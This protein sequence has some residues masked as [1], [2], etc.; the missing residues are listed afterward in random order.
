MDKISVIVPV[1]KVE[2]YLDKCVESIVNQTYQ[3]L[4]I[5]LVDDGSPDRCP[6]MCD[7][8]AKKDPRI[9]VIHKKNGGLSS[10]RNAG[11]DQACGDYLM[12]VDSDDYISHCMC[13]KL[14]QSIVRENAD[15][16]ICGVEKK[17]PNGR[18]SEFSNI[19]DGVL[20]QKAFFDKMEGVC[21]WCWV[22]AWNKLY[23]KSIFDDLRYP[24]GKL[25]EDD[26][27]IHKIISKTQSISCVG[28]PLYFYVQRENSI[29]SSKYTVKNLDSVEAMLQRC[30]FFIDHDF[31]SRRIDF[32]LKNAL[33]FLYNN[34]TNQKH[35]S[36]F[37]ARY[38]QL[39]SY[40]KTIWE[41]A[42]NFDLPLSRKLYYSAN[43]L[44]PKIGYILKKIFR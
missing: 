22:V 23:K 24:E 25:Y 37:N 42:K 6:Q 20:T 13:E 41:K 21:G 19:S 39:I 31:E 7:E 15:M 12:F 34:F 17:Y 1:Y 5:I 27:I 9:K 18:E 38:V 4:E 11:I 44:S 35:D 29:I 8:W 14:A 40:Y 32:C 3:E 10:A 30:Q 2:E 26:F 33:A 16:C 36:E 28:E 43:A